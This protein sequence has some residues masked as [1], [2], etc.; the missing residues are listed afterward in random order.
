MQKINNDINKYNTYDVRR[1]AYC[2]YLAEMPLA[3]CRPSTCRYALIVL[4]DIPACPNTENW[5]P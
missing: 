4:K 2:F 1:D 5:S 3:L